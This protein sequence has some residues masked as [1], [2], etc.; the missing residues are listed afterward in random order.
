MFDGIP[1]QLSGWSENFGEK[2][3]K[4]NFLLQKIPTNVEVG[5]KFYPIF[6]LIRNSNKFFD[7]FFCGQKSLKIVFFGP[8]FG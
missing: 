7:Y 3:F 2:N 4:F 6:R 5:W 1:D 8:L